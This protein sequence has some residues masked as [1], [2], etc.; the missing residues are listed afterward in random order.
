M[1]HRRRVLSVLQA[2]SRNDWRQDGRGLDRAH[3]A[4]PGVSKRQASLSRPREGNTLGWLALWAMLGAGI[5]AAGYAAV[6]GG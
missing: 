3:G 2:G 1:M 6:F 5:W 4:A